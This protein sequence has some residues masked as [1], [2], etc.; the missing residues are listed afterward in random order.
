[1]LS[2]IKI[3]ARAFNPK[4]FF[5]YTNIFEEKSPITSPSL[6]FKEGALKALALTLVGT[7]LLFAIFKILTII[8]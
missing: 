3:V 6:I 8:F 7:H 1:M 2:T 5:K 4:N